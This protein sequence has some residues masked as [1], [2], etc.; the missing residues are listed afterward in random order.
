MHAL[1]ECICIFIHNLQILSSMG[2][3]SQIQ[4]VFNGTSSFF[5]ISRWTSGHSRSLPQYR[6]RMDG[7]LFCW[8]RLGR[9][10]ILK[11]MLWV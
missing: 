8:Q 7:R 2:K 6:L 11:K 3:A 1:P 10:R 9:V 4:G 5:I